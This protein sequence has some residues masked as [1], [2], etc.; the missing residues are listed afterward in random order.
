VL[1]RHTPAVRSRGRRRSTFG[2]AAVAAALVLAACGGDG[3]GSSEGSSGGGDDTEAVGTPTPGGKVV[4]ALE[5]ETGSGWCLPESSLAISGIQVAR[6]VYDT[7]TV[8]DENADY[9]PFLAE[10]LV[11]DETYTTWTMKLRDGVTF[12][13]GTPLDATVVKNNLDAYRGKYPG[14]SALLLAFVFQNIADV[15]V[16]DPM[17]V[18]IT[19]ATPWPALPA[20]LFGS[21]RIGIMAQAQLDD[22]D[23]CDTNLIGTGPF[24]M[25]EWNIDQNFTATRNED[26]WYS[27]ADGNQL[28]Y[29]DEIEFR[30]VADGNAR[31]NG[32]LAEEFDMTHV[33]QATD[34]EAV[35]EEAEPSDLHVIESAEFGEV[36]YQMMNISKAPFD[37]KI[38]REAV[39]AAVDM[40]VYNQT[41]NLG[42]LTNA[43]GP[44]APGEIGHEDDTGWPGYDL[45]KAKD[46]VAEYESTTGQPLAFTLLST[47][48]PGTLKAV[49]IFQQM[50]IKAGM[51]VTLR[52]VEQATLID[53]AIAGNFQMLDWRNHPGGDPDGQYDW[54]KSDSVVNFSKIDDPEIDRLLD[55]GRATADRAERQRIYGDVS[56]RFASEV[57]NLWM[58]WTLWTVASQG[59]VHGVFGPALPDGAAPFEGL[60]TGHSVAGLW[61]QQ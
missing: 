59:D 33:G 22:P 61:V 27:D 58:Q 18:T 40:D 53:E 14:R 32:L 12:H 20:A 39:V 42:I 5:A 60:A 16:T 3:G 24:V 10:S 23:T 54:W 37:S 44:F 25:E 47:P 31:V 28:P 51:D 43:N 46:L 56:K 13:D 49:Q 57:Y 4:Y 29:L 19:T 48:D 7:L 55:E 35:R 41:Q 45:E 38:A 11:P 6:A 50:F 8:P 1:N 52:Q 34:I 30:P 2:A 36:G 15:A 26:Y 21:G 9:Q 17:T